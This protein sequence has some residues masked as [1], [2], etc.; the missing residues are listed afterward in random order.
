MPV[1]ARLQ[2]RPVGETEAVRVTLPV[3]PFTEAAVI[4]EVPIIPTLTVTLV[5]DAVTVKSVR[6]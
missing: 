6:V 1:G 3:N 2:I 4:V 5:G